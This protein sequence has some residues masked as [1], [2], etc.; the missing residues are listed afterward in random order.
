MAFQG[1]SY[2]SEEILETLLPFVND[3]IGFRMYPEII[4]YYSIN[5]FG[6]T[7]AIIFDEFNKILRIHD[8]KSGI[9]P[10]KMDQLFNICSII[11]SRI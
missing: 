9:T 1:G 8:F 3:A 5:C 11:L 10:A 2:D 7:D 6:T 4:L